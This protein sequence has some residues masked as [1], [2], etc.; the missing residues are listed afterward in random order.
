MVRL[1]LARASTR[2]VNIVVK[3]KRT[4]RGIKHSLLY[5]EPR[6]QQVRRDKNTPSAGQ[7]SVTYQHEVD[8]L[9]GPI[10][11]FTEQDA[12]RS[13][14][15]RRANVVS[16]TFEKTHGEQ[17]HHLHRRSRPYSETGSRSSQD[18]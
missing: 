18:T 11:V 1:T 15:R 12:P 4:S 3:K 17:I 5:V 9:T 7:G 6:A 16:L 10:T 8:P 2:A 13:K 14:R